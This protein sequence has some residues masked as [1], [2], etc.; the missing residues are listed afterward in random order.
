MKTNYTDRKRLAI[1]SFFLLSFYVLL[2]IQFYRIQIIQGEKWT[3]YALAQHQTTLTESFRRGSFFSNTAIKKGHPEDNQPLVLDVMKFHL[4]IDPESLPCLK[5][6]EISDKIFQFLNTNEE[7]KKSLL[8]DFYRKSRSRKIALWLDKSVKEQIQNWWREY[9]KKN[10][11]ASNAIYFQKDYRRS[12]P[13]KSLLGQILQTVQDEKDP[14][15]MQAIPIG[16]LELKFNE[17]LKGKTGRRIINR[18]PL[19]PLDSGEIVDPP[20]DGAD[21]YL[22]INHYLQAIAEAELKKGVEKAEAKGGWA[23]MLDPKNGH[24]LALAQYPFFNP[25]NYKDYYNDQEKIELTRV[26]AVNDSFEPASVFKVVTAAICFMANE[27]LIK[28]GLKPLFSP[29]EKIATTNGNFP[30]RVKPLKDGRLHKFLN[31]DLAMQKSSNIYFGIL[32]QRVIDRLGNNWYRE[33]LLQLGFGRKTNVQIPSE[34]KG[35]VPC[36][37]KLHPNGTLEWS[38]PTPYSLAIG[39]NI[40]VN[41][42]QMVRAVSVIANG[43]YLIEPSICRKI[44]RAGKIL[45]DHEKDRGIT[46]KIMSKNSTDRILKS[47][48]GVTKFRGSAPFAELKGYSQCGKSGTSEKIVSGKYSE[49]DYIA[50]F[51]GMAPAKDPRFVL[52][53]AIDEPPKKWVEGRGKNHHGGVSAAPVFKEI[54]ERALTFLGVDPDGNKAKSNAY[55]RE[56]INLYNDWNQ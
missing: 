16:G 30:G 17:Y 50:F 13:F 19:N 18:S 51:L 25:E 15:T 41:S 20:L 43:G 26:K 40:L 38:L 14:N 46:Y 23:I 24:I 8:I 55:A 47:L 34:S 36:P 44:T 12:Y 29:D 54:A 56:L 21:I 31:L 2:I 39:H 32:I 48:I 6:I 28:K 1:I 5:K 9:A 45:Y 27:E 42:L 37:G 53:V 11:I 7:D 4:F 22:T 35:L 10:K 3:Q 33:K 49:K 52:L